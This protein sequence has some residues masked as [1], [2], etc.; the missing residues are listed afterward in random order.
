M[1][2]H[3]SRLL[4]LEDP[5]R[6]PDNAGGFI[7]TWQPLGEVWA[8]V[9]ARTGRSGDL[10]SVR[11]GQVAWRIVVRGAPVG[12]PSRPMPGQRFREG[13][14]HYRIEAVAERDPAGSYLICDASE[15][16]AA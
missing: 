9:T 12:V 4:V 7:E 5:Q 14:R 2:A 1:S 15:E 6:V 8:E 10:G 3:L 11:T 16:V 13:A